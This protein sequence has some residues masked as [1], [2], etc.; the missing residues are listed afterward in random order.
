MAGNLDLVQERAPN[1]ELLFYGL[2]EGLFVTTPALADEVIALSNDGRLW[3]YR[4]EVV[5][6]DARTGGLYVRLKEVG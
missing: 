1:G 6:R 3:P 4:A 5:G 2:G